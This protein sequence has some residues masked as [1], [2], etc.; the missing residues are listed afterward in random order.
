MDSIFGNQNNTGFVSF[1]EIEN[2][3]KTPT[4]YQHFYE[5]P[6]KSGPQY[7]PSDEFPPNLVD[8]DGQ[9]FSDFE[10]LDDDPAPQVDHE[11][12]MRTGE[13]I[14]RLIDT[15]IDF[16][17]SNFVARNGESYRADERDLQDIAEAWGEVSEEHNWN[18]GPEWTLAILYVMVYGPLVK[19]AVADRRMA[20][21]EAR[22]KQLEERM[23]AYEYQAPQ[24]EK[25]QSNGNKVRINP[26]YEPPKA[27]PYTHR[28]APEAPAQD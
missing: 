3:F 14:A 17:L 12:A 27:S 8:P 4:Q 28:P 18:I 26:E 1:D 19:Q 11:H 5:N 2:A 22:T 9:A 20:E 24:P 16:T 15:G 23:A 13:R 10:R 25:P 7:E 21:L 6:E